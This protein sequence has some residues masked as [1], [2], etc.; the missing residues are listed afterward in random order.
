MSEIR[1]IFEVEIESDSL[2]EYLDGEGYLLDDLDPDNVKVKYL[3]EIS[4]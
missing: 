4:K 2:I 3:F 1:N